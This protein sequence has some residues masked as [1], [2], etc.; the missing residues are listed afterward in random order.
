MKLTAMIVARNELDRYL[1]PCV[2]HLLEFCDEIRIL[3]DASTDGLDQTHAWDVG[4]VKIRTQEQ[5]TFYEHEGRTRQALLDWALEGDPTHLLAIDADEFVADGPAL[6]YRMERDGHN[7]TGVWKLAMTEVWRADEDNLYV[8]RDGHW[9]PHPAGI[10]FI[11]PPDR[12]TDR[13][14]RR[15]WVMQDKA[16]A[17]G[18]V[19]LHTQMVS[20]RTTT[21]PV[22]KIYH[23]GWA[24][25]ADRASRHHRYVVH[26][27]GV[28]HKSTH[29]DSIMFPDSQVSMTADP[30]PPG[31]DKATL[32]ARVNRGS[33]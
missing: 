25:Q 28:H 22:T 8:R 21:E 11:V 12:Y 14:K 5:T 27:G 23:F 1:R 7:G 32:L 15:H 20:N 9:G 4:P 3:N 10:A 6:R 24:C 26:D 2:D 31:L 16:L 33:S 29:L 17:C 13:Q 19:P 18:R 30:W